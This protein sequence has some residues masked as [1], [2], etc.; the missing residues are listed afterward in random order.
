MT[1]LPFYLHAKLPDGR[2]G[3][4]LRIYTLFGKDNLLDGGRMVAVRVPSKQHT[5]L[6]NGNT[7]ITEYKEVHIPH[8]YLEIWRYQ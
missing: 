5:E 3:V 4:V 1:K 2:Q 7:K 8:R 6:L